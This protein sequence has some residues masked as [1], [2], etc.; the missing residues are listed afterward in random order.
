MKVHKL[1]K[2]VGLPSK[3]VIKELKKLGVSIKTHMSDIE[4]DACNLFIE[5]LREEGKLKEQKTVKKG[6]SSLDD[7]SDGLLIPSDITVG[8]LATM[9]NVNATALIKKLIERGIFANVNQMLKPELAVEVAIELGYDPD[10][11]RVADEKDVVVRTKI[12]TKGSVSRAPIVTVMGHVDHGKTC[13]LDAIR[14][15]DVAGSEKGSITQHIGAY[16][17]NV[18]KR[19]VV[20]IDTPGHEAFTSMRARGAHVTDIV[21]L[22]VAADDGIMPQTIEAINHAKAANVPI[23][24]AINKIDKSDADVER[25]KQQLSEQDLTPEEWGGKTVCVE[26]SAIKK[27]GLD[28]LLE[29]LLLE[30]DMLELT[31]DT[32]T[33]A[34]GT[35]I[36]SRIDKGKG[37]V[38]TVIIQEGTLR[39]GDAFIS[40]M[41]CG[42]VRALINDK[43][44][45]VYEAGPSTPVEILGFSEAPEI[46]EGFLAVESEKVA[47]EMS[48]RLE[49]GKH[50]K[51]GNTANFN[52]KDD[53]TK[54]IYLII[55]GDVRGSIE[56]LCNSL[57]VLS[58]EKVKVNI[59]HSGIGNIN[60]SDVLLASSSGAIILGFGVHAES[61][62]LDIAERN[63]VSIR[64]YSI[65]Y[66]AVDNIKKLVEG[67][68]EPEYKKVLIGKAEV[69]Q[70]FKISKTT[71][72]CGSYVLEGKIRRDCVATLTREGKPVYQGKISSLRR[73]KNDAKE[74]KAELECGIGLDNCKDVQ[75]GDIIEAHV[76][77]KEKLK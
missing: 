49:S 35:V 38:A 11:I 26:V 64:Y 10:L 77:E 2:K 54:V 19:D 48:S 28:N 69:R 36:E 66:E 32:S 73:F 29:M 70:I 74:V 25:V 23:V 5:M 42:K 21:V 8:Q 24:V 15:A 44:K 55:K 45:R 12:K 71:L 65:I 22:V 51:G 37:H 3:E 61:G 30:T 68:I 7:S 57:E 72:I 39:M 20:F 59:I 13:L 31:V 62:A 14:H 52:I 47:K 1:A 18:N 43:G 40:G 34:K 67:L 6:K 60:E 50:V 4:D 76:M 58:L 33:P 53:K 56:P 75:E 16:K 63:D 46:G 9:I 41:C 27:Q 17:L